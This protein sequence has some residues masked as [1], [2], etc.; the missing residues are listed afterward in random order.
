MQGREGLKHVTTKA[1]KV[2]NLIP[3]KY[4]L[5]ISK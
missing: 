5:D 1:V 4:I 2:Q 3:S